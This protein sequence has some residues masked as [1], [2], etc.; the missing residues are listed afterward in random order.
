MILTESWFTGGLPEVCDATHIPS[1]DV[2]VEPT[3]SEPVAALKRW[4]LDGQCISNMDDAQ[5]THMECILWMPEVSH[6]ETSC[7]KVMDN[8]EVFFMLVHVG[9]PS[10]A[11]LVEGR[12]K[13]ELYHGCTQWAPIGDNTV[14]ISSSAQL[15]IPIQSVALVTSQ[16]DR[17]PLK[18]S[19]W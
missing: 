6:A 15:T 2:L 10:S 7:N 16:L 19:A 17:S 14:S 11:Y 12:S 5:V 1:R 13:I 18:R 3:L 4:S 8:F 9:A